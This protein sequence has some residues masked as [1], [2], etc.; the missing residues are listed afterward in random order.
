VVTGD[1]TI[2]HTGSRV[3]GDNVPWTEFV[4]SFARVKDVFMPSYGTIGVVTRAAIRI[5]PLLEKQAAPLVRFADFATAY[6]FLL[7]ISKSPMMDKASLI[8]CEEF[9]FI[10]GEALGTY[11]DYEAGMKRFKEEFGEDV[12]ALPWLCVFAMRGFKETVEGELKALERIAKEYGGNYLSEEEL[13]KRYPEQWKAWTKRYRDFKYRET[14]AAPWI[15][16]ELVS[17]AQFPC[18]V[19]EAIKLQPALEEK[20]KEYGIQETGFMCSMHNYGQTTTLRY[21]PFVGS[22]TEEDIEKAF[23][24]QTEITEW[25]LRNYDVSILYD[26]FI[27]NDPKNPENV[28]GRAK[29][30]RRIMSAVQREFDPDGVMNP[31]MKKFTLR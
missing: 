8:R 16:N 1:G 3:F 26:E 7:D 29:P 9:F 4:K 6:R 12:E 11:F 27:F 21:I 13:E 18:A 28:V 23:K 22:K 2:I 5:W 17:S 14:D 19:E 20:C 25:A 15:M 30:I 10:G 24:M 31:A